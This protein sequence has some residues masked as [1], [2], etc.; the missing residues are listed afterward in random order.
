[1]IDVVFLL[2]VFFML[3]SRFGQDRA[4]P[5]SVGGGT[6]LCSGPPL[7]VDIGAE[8]LRWHGVPVSLDALAGEIGRPAPSGTGKALRRQYWRIGCLHSHRVW[9]SRA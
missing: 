5:L 2:L 6:T 8:D 1:M 4:L 3:A 9:T 7:L